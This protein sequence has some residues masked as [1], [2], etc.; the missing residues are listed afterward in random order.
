[1]E[2]GG[3]QPGPGRAT[4]G[5]LA[6]A[7]GLAVASNYYAQPLLPAIA[8]ALGVPSGQAGLVVT[9]SQAG[10]A[11][12]LVLLVPLGDL[13]ERRRLAA[14]LSGAVGLGLLALGASLDLAWLLGAAFAVGMASVLAQSMVAFAAALAPPT[15]RGRVVGTVMSGLLLGVLLA[16]T[17]AGLLAATGTWRTV[18]LA[19]GTAML[20][21]APLLARLLPVSRPAAPA[22]YA[23][24]VASVAGLVRQEPVLALRCVYGFLS[25]GAFS[26]LW[27]S[28][29]FLLAHHY[30]YPSP[31]IGLF[32]LL[33]AAGVTAASVAG[34]LSDRGG[35]KATTGV[36]ASLLAAPW[37]ALWAGGR[38]LAALVVGIVAL[39]AGASALHI[40]NQGEIYRLRPDAQGRVTAAYMVV[41][42]AG[43]AAGSAASATVWPLAGWGGVCLA[44]SGFGV[45]ALAVWAATGLAGRRGGAGRSASLGR[46]EPAP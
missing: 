43:G 21:L 31:V 37:A 29:A 14:A 5:L 32:G 16:R 46:R 4:V 38:S 44:G 17:L 13:V 30:R 34:R 33:G 42:F 8:R 19:A 26:V 9:V 45:A 6:L 40:T 24:L 1:M 35:A 23:R 10:Y 22:G 41:Y 2:L 20:A 39:D 15:Q 12:G 36:A 11:S 27:T 18:Y 3:P 28:L 25:F 7:T